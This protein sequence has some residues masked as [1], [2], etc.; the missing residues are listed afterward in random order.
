MFYNFLAY[1]QQ[2]L[3]FIL[4]A[5]ST[6]PFL[7]ALGLIIGRRGH[8]AFCLQGSRKI[9]GMAMWLACVGFFYF[10]ISYLTIVLP[11]GL[12]KNVLSSIFLPQGRPWLA[13]AL[14]W[15][16]GI[17]ILFL[18]KAS[19]K[20]IIAPAAE[21]RYRFRLIRVAFILFS[22][23]SFVFMTALFLEHWPFAGLPEGMSME[24]AAIAIARNSMRHFFQSF[25]PAGAFA[26]L[27]AAWFF[28]HPS[29]KKVKLE[30]AGS[31]RWFA[32]WAIAGAV[33][34]LFISWGL[35]LASW[36]RATLPEMANPKLI[37]LGLLFQ[38]L[39][40][41]TWIWIIFRPD[42]STPRIVLAFVLTLINS[43][44]PL[45]ARLAL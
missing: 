7:I 22:T 25:S 35:Q 2:I 13:A 14:C 1:I 20:R 6:L 26:L 44:W 39:A 8:A 27:Y 45:L 33:P 31:L 30:K 3:F 24:R 16:A 41:A 28:S 12:S 4:S 5:A 10:T 17:F 23:T 42:K 37:L 40:I 29:L 43:F 36:S 32:F 38:T 11:Y 34:S 15:L 18:A 9:S 19:L 21:D